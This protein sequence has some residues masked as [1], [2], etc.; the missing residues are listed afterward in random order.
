MEWIILFL[1]C[2]ILF[3]SLVDLK[4][5]KINIWCG[6]MAVLLQLSI[7]SQAITHGFYR[8]NNPVISILGSSGL[9]VFGPVFTIGVLFA[10]FHPVNKWMRIINVLVIAGIFSIQE[11]FLISRHVLVYLSW[12]YIDSITVN[13]CAIIILSWFSIVILYKRKGYWI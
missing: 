8:I 3:I 4:T 1:I 11:L 7:D 6:I 2:W 10:Q 5:L 12:H 13:I 9:F